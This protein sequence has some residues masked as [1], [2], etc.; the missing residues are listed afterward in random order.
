MHDTWPT[1]ELTLTTDAD[2]VPALVHRQPFS[3]IVLDSSA[4]SQGLP[5]LIANM[6]AFRPQ[7]PVL[8]LTAQPLARR[9][10]QELRH[11]ATTLLPRHSSPQELVQAIHPWLSNPTGSRLSSTASM[12]RHLGPPTPF[13]RRELD[14]LRLVVD[15]C[16]NLEIAR[17]LGLSVRTVESHRR[18][19]LQKAGVRSLIGLV[20]QAVR[21][22]WIS[23]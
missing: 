19:L 1:L 23:S 12:A 10:R 7:Q 13:S 16:T 17:H 8:V 4:T 11:S 15:D 2:Q 14:V 18:A 9:C 22:G 3:L 20:A 5:L 6:R 21:G